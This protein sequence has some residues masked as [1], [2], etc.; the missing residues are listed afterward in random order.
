MPEPAGK[1]VNAVNMKRMSQNRRPGWE[2]VPE[3]EEEWD[4]EEE[5][6]G[7][8]VWQQRGPSGEE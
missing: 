1:W 4:P 5:W 3:P 7:V 2:N 8:P 6:G